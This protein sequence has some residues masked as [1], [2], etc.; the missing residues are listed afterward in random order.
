[1]KDSDSIDTTAMTGTTGAIGTTGTTSRRANNDGATHAALASRRACV[2]SA[3]ALG[4]LGFT[5]LL[6]C[7]A[8][9]APSAGA[10]TSS[11]P[12]TPESRMSIENV[13]TV[14]A[15]YAAFGKGD[16]AAI[17]ARSASDTKWDFNGGRAE[18]PWHKPVANRGQVAE[19]LGTFGQANEVQRFE[20]REFISSGP[21]VIVEVKIQYRVRATARQV[22]QDQLHWWTFGPDRLVARLRHFEDTA[23]VLA[24]VKG[25]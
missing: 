10:S 14:Q 17:Q 16:A 4:A 13:A 21:H 1:M 7:A 23:Q 9:A 24:A 12:S 20:P 8:D 18:V 22:T 2:F 15:I 3:A 6:G 11:T 5:P 25:A 19:F